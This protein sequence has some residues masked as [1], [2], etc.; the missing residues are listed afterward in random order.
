M[1]TK[2]G[3]RADGKFVVMCQT[4]DVCKS[5]GAPVPYQIA[6]YLDDSAVRTSPNVN[7]LGKP[8]FTMHSRVATVVGDEAG[9]GLGVMSGSHLGMCRPIDHTPTVRA[10]G[11]FVVFHRDS[12][13]WMNCAGP[14]GPGNTMG[15]LYYLG[16]M[17]P[18]EVSPAGTVP[19]ADPSIAAETAAEASFLSSALDAVGGI[20]GAIAGAQQLYGLATT[21]WSNP[22]AVL[23]AVGGVAGMAG[24]GDVA[25]AVGMAQQAYALATTD[26]SNPGAILGAAMNLG[27]P[28][29]KGLLGGGGRNAGVLEDLPPGVVLQ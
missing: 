17:F 11:H 12:K 23:G 21:D 7:F 4:P 19:D 8:V 10:N 16:P 24:L 6:G 2:E 20:E 18:V 26:W 9:V 22:M 28:A 15:R 14:D 3:G 25:E 13:F 29:L 27:G 5:P 1:A